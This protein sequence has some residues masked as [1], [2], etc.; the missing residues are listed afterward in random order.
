VYEAESQ[1][2]WFLQTGNP[3]NDFENGNN[4]LE[5]TYFI[6]FSRLILSYW[7]VL[8]LIKNQRNFAQKLIHF[9]FKLK[10]DHSGASWQAESVQW[11]HVLAGRDGHVVGV[12]QAELHNACI[13]GPQCFSNQETKSWSILD[14]C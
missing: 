12:D 14:T 3:V 8:L 7:K 11:E 5:E 4:L 9:K 13:M 6:K 1:I 2:G 10:S